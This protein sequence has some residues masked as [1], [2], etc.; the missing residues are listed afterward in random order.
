MLLLELR[1]QALWINPLVYLKNT[2]IFCDEIVKQRLWNEEAKTMQ[3]LTC[4]HCKI[5]HAASILY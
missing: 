4:A 2:G 1:V 5:L 3:L